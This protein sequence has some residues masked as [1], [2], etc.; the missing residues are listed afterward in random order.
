VRWQQN[1]LIPLPY[2]SRAPG[3]LFNAFSINPSTLRAALAEA[4]LSAAD[5]D[6][7]YDG[8]AGIGFSLR[9]EKLG[10]TD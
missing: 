3:E 4:P 6:F 7:F 5:V 1:K 8:G 10:I 2:N 9:G